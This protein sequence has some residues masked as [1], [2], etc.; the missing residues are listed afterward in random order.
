MFSINI[1]VISVQI[2]SKADLPKVGF[3]NTG[4]SKRT[5]CWTAEFNT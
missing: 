1:H 5:S 2:V 4:V 3:R